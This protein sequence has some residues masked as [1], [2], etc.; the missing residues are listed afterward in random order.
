MQEKKNLR[1]EDGKSAA[2]DDAFDC[3]LLACVALTV[4]VG[5]C[6]GSY[7]ANMATAGLEL[8]LAVGMTGSAGLIVSG[9]FAKQSYKSWRRYAAWDDRIEMRKRLAATGIT[10]A[11]DS[12]KLEHSTTLIRKKL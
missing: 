1:W 7:V 10:R 11:D 9:W 12:P 2:F 5:I 6:F 3:F 8:E 4:T